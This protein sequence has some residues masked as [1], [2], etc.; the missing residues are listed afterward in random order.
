[1]KKTKELGQCQ[2]H[3]KED[4]Q[5]GQMKGERTCGSIAHHCQKHITAVMSKVRI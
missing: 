4:L 1:M 2:G 5:K 3:R